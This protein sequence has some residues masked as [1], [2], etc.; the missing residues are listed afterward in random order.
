MAVL[1]VRRRFTA[2]E[3][4]RMADV[5]IFNEDDRV[6][7]IEGEIVEM[8]PIGSRHAACVDRLNELL[9]QHFA[10]VALIRVQNPVRLS[11]DSE[12]QPD[13]A[14]LRRKADFYAS[15]E[16]TPDDVIL[17]VEV[18]D[19]SLEYDRRVKVPL[20]AHSGIREV[21]LI[22]L[23]RETVT[24]YQDPAP[25]GYRTIRTLRRGDRLAPAAFADRELAIADILG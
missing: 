23:E 4:H 11:D 7:L 5:G 9:V 2:D 21:W 16:P 18:A 17:L 3:Y 25:S 8:T 20:Y 22:G 14:L 19:T 15:R 10:G 1:L 24:V 12:P 6:E 13:L